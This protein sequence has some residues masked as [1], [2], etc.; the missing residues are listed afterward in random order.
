MPKAFILVSEV[1]V[2]FR[3]SFRYKQWKVF[4]KIVRQKCVCIPTRKDP[5]KTGKFIRLDK[6]IPQK[7]HRNGKCTFSH[8]CCSFRLMIT[9]P[10]AYMHTLGHNL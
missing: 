10:G 7:W 2:R 1:K 3:F 5:G 4:T 9:R 6:D 8:L